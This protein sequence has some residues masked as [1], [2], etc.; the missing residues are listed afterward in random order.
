V[1]IGQQQNLIIVCGIL[2]F[3]GAFLVLLKK[4]GERSG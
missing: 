4:Q 3:V 2:V 1:A